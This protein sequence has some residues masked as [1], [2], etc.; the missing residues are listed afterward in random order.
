V[1]PIR[2]GVSIRTRA[3]HLGEVYARLY[4]AFGPQ[5][6]WPAETPFEVMVG[7]ILTQH[8]S[9]TNVEQAIDRLKE[10]GRF[11][12]RGLLEMPVPELEQRLRPSGAFR[13]KTRRLRAFL[14]YF[15]DRFGSCLE[16]MKREP[17]TRLRKELLE[18]SGIGPETA[19]CI[20]LYGLERPSFVV[21]AYTRRIFERL[22]RLEPALS[23]TQLR[24]EFQRE[25]MPD[26]STYNEYH[27]LIVH[28]G[29]TT[30]RPTP[31]CE[32]C[33]LQDICVEAARSQKLTAIL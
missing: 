1:S 25:L 5:N 21:D 24:D 33:P 2:N 20:L 3:G 4:D 11:S 15:D 23:Y 28:L 31:R 14:N 26:V 10:S 29:K 16:T 30:C 32:A 12:P 13:V 9:W 7:A 22:G 17:V 18:V 6:W 8:T 19:D 27:A